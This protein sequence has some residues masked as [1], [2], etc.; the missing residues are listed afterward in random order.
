MRPSETRRRAS[1]RLSDPDPVRFLQGELQELWKE[2]VN[3]LQSQSRAPAPGMGMGIGMGP[4]PAA[5]KAA[6]HRHIPVGPYRLVVV[7]STPRP[8]CRPGRHPGHGQQA[9]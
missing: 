5:P 6:G 4:G 7:P 8:G 1:L 2:A 9:N 3:A